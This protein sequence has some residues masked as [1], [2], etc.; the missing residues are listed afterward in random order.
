MKSSNQSK[1]KD[2]SH[3][4]LSPGLYEVRGRIGFLEHQSNQFAHFIELYS[5][6]NEKYY[7]NGGN[8]YPAAGFNA[9]KPNARKLEPEEITKEIREQWDQRMKQACSVLCGNDECL[10]RFP[11]Q[12]GTIHSQKHVGR[13]EAY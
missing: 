8:R 10:R 1:L 4:R 2:L 5:P 11:K 13:R 9:K 7:T 3:I 6:S 12:C